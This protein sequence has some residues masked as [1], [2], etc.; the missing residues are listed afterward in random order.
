MLIVV[1]KKI[2]IIGVKTSFIEIKFSFI[3]PKTRLTQ[4]YNKLNYF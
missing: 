2:K 4:F 3:E 1:F